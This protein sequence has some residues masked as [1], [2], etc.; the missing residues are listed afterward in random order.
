MTC[1]YLVRDA[2]L[3]TLAEAVDAPHAC[4]AS[5]CSTNLTIL[6]TVNHSLSISYAPYAESK[7]LYQ[8]DMA[9]LQRLHG[10]QTRISPTTF[11]PV[12]KYAYDQGAIRHIG[13][14]S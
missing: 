14:V 6:A 12:V 4:L 5:Q 3:R 1:N 7:S 2:E 10:F 11:T 13:Q 9:D 8:L